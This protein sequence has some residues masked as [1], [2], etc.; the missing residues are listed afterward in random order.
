MENIPKDPLWEIADKLSNQELTALCLTNK[1]ITIKYVIT[2]SF[3]SGE[4]IKDLEI[5]R[6]QIHY[7]KTV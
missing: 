5:L 4:F 1:D 6:F 7:D 3:G 2:N